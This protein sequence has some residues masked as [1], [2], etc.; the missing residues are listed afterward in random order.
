MQISRGFKWNIP[1]YKHYIIHRCDACQPITFSCKQISTHRASHILVPLENLSTE[2]ISEPPNLDS[3]T[4]Q[5]GLKITLKDLCDKHIVPNHT[6]SSIDAHGW[7][8]HFAMMIRDREFSTGISW[9]NSLCY[10]ELNSFPKT[11]MNTLEALG[12]EVIDLFRK[13]LNDSD[14]AENMFDTCLVF[15]RMVLF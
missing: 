4:W 6:T 2:N 12:I 1:K 3:A 15:L 9:T 14:A 7:T 5:E 11:H 13:V 8:I 10:K